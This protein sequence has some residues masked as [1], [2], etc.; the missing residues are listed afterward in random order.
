MRKQSLLFDKTFQKINW[1]GSFYKGTRVGH[2]EEYDLNFVIN[3]PFKEKN[4]KVDVIFKI[5]DVY[6]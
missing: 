6:R 2:P 5:G 3:L 1:V 4:I